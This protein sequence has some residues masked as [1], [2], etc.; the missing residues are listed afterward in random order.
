M[1]ESPPVVP[2]ISPNTME[3]SQP[4]A[5]ATLALAAA[6]AADDRKGADI[7]ILRVT[8]VSYL[9]DYFL[10]VTGFSPV[11]VKAIARSIEAKLS[12]D[13][14]RHP[15]RMEGQ[16]E[17]RWVLQDYGDLIVHIFMPQ[18]REFYNLEA[19]WGHADQVPFIPSAPALSSDAAPAAGVAA[20]LC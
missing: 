11:Q 10:L 19:F 6:E 8:E 3:P 1:T 20:D 2:L 14:H 15:K 18:E 7:V 4:L 17:G 12:V 9:A 5:D 13:H 16:Q